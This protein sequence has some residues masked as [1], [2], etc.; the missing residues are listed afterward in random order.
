MPN[1]KLIIHPPVDEE[2]RAF[3]K[4]YY[5]I[6]NPFTHFARNR[7]IVDSSD[8]LIATPFNDLDRKKGGTWYTINYALKKGVDTIIILPNGI[9]ENKK[10]IE[11]LTFVD[12]YEESLKK[13]HTKELLQ[14][15]HSSYSNSNREIIKKELSKREHIPN[16]K[17]AKKIRQEKAKK[18]R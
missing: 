18:G 13:M 10:S 16:K 7:N 2:L 8:L 11:G 15:L 12:E 14:M 17:E 3:C 4:N 1:A 9:E 6:R 5:E